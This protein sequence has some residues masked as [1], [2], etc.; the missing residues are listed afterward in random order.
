MLKLAT[1]C[2]VTQNNDQRETR[3][4]EEGRDLARSLKLSRSRSGGK[5]RA[6]CSVENAISQN[7]CGVTVR[8]GSKQQA[9]HGA[10]HQQI[11]SCQS[12]GR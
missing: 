8:E 1:G 10:P 9:Q 3:E 6:G 12:G 2:P 11:G 5:G 7:C 4:Q